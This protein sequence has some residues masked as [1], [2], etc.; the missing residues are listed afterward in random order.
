[1]FEKDKPDTEGCCTFSESQALDNLNILLEENEPR[2]LIDT[3]DLEVLLKQ[4]ED[5]S[6]GILPTKSSLK[7]TSS[8]VSCPQF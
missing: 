2:Y 1:M 4:I 8:F 3:I 6:V 7:K 5:P